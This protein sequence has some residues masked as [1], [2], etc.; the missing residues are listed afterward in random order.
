M[1][2]GDDFFDMKDKKEKLGPGALHKM[3]KKPKKPELLMKKKKRKHKGKGYGKRMR[4]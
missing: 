1:E 4:Y 2:Y 3:T